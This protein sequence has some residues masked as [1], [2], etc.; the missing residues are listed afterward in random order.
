MQPERRWSIGSRFYGFDLLL[1]G[2][3]VDRPVWATL[4]LREF[5][6]CSAFDLF[7]KGYKKKH[8]LSYF[9]RDDV[10]FCE[11]PVAMSEV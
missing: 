4:S 1:W 9:S 8:T 5:I 11:P 10:L 7:A 6:A 3:M 2:Y